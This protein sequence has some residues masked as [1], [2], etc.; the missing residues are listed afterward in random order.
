MSCLLALTGAALQGVASPPQFVL[1]PNIALC[2]SSTS[3]VHV[4]NNTYQLADSSLPISTTVT[5]INLLTLTPLI[6]YRT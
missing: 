1:V 3:K 6:Q 4:R 2:Y 5:A